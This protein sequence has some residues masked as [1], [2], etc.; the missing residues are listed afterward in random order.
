MDN[1]R[2][3]KAASW[4][5]FIILGIVLFIAILPLLIFLGWIAVLGLAMYILYMIILHSSDDDEANPE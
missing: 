4:S 2:K 5:M 1:F 3:V